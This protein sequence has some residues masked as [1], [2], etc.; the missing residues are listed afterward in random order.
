MRS[1]ILVFCAATLTAHAGIPAAG[2][3]VIP[4]PRVPVPPVAATLES[5][6]RILSEIKQN[7]MDLSGPD[8][9]FEDTE[10]DPYSENAE[11]IIKAFDRAYEEQTGEPLPFNQETSSWS[12]LILKTAGCYQR[13]CPVFAYIS[14]RKQT[15]TLYLGGEAVDVW[16]VSTGIGNRTPYIN[17]TATSRIY[18]R[19]TSSRYPG[20]DY[21]GLGNMPYAVFIVGGIAIHGTPKSNWKRLGSRASHGCIRLHPEHAY[22]FNRLVRENGHTN[23]WILVD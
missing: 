1:L 14:R 9:E 7:L 3:V 19:Y 23:V 12:N 4:G 5:N 10:F 8:Y 16:P 15:L 18:Q 13:S 17:K 2:T 11:A 21:A 6:L 20:G 22:A